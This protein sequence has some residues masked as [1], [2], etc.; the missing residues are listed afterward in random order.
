MARGGFGPAF[1]GQLARDIA[2]HLIEGV[3]ASDAASG[4]G[5]PGSIH[6]P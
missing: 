3:A 5:Q 1:D 4:P 2:A 6:R